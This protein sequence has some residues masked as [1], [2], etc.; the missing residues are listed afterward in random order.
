MAFIHNYTQIYPGNPEG[1][2]PAFLE[3]HLALFVL[4]I[5]LYKMF[6]IQSKVSTNLQNPNS[7]SKIRMPWTAKPLITEKA[8][9]RKSN[10]K[11]FSGALPTNPQIRIAGNGFRANARKLTRGALTGYPPMT[12]LWRAQRVELVKLGLKLHAKNIT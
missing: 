1:K 4:F 11:K 10:P 5:T 12:P 2:K 6:T 7:N 3:L 9:K 8:K